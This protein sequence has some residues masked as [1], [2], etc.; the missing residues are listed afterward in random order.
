MDVIKAA[1]KKHEALSIKY[2]NKERI[3]KPYALGTD[4]KGKELMLSFQQTPKKEW[5][6]IRVAD[7]K[8]IE[9]MAVD[10]GPLISKSRRTGLA[11]LVGRFQPAGLC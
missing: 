5:Q 2:R 8:G 10:F 6:L 4:T 11:S 1:I 3:V 7:I 9:P